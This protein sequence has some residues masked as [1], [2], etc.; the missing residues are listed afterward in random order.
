VG[1]HDAFDVVHLILKI[2]IVNCVMAISCL[3]SM[4]GEAK[5]QV[6]FSC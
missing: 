5:H 3:F 6:V 4:R 1:F 2:D